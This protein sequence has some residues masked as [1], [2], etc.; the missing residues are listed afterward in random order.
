MARHVKTES[1][2][3]P[4]PIRYMDGSSLRRPLDLPHRNNYVLIGIIVAAAV[5]GILIGLH[6][7]DV[8][9]NSQVRQE[10]TV[11]QTI[12]RGVTLD[13]PILDTYVSASNAD[14]S[15][16]LTAAGYTTIDMSTIPGA[17]SAASSGALDVIKLPSDVTV[18][19][20]AIAYAQG[21]SS[22]SAEDAARYL[23]GS[24][25]LTVDRSSGV[26]MKV[27]YADFASKTAATAIQSAIT[28]EGWAKSTMGDSGVDA[29]GN[30]YQNGT[31]TLDGAT[32][33]W[34][35]SVCSLSEIYSNS[36]LPTD[37]LYVGVRLAG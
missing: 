10:A 13:L 12:N 36:G 30:T 9:I 2:S 18:A 6:L 28:T 29:S 25:R 37:A 5:F 11:E 32:Y 21:I 14:I 26:D 19:D 33:N 24:W 3:A 27:K 23:S 1:A 35:I 17:S 4:S 7:Y 31:I 8:F 15:A 16:A 22:L 20:A 34:S